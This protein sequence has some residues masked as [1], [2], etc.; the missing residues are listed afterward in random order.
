MSVMYDLINILG[1]FCETLI[2]YNFLEIVAKKEVLSKGKLIVTWAM[3]I[4]VQILFII[5]IKQQIVITAAL[6]V[7]MIV[8]SLFFRMNWF[9]RILSSV[10]ILAK[11]GIV[12]K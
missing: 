12:S 5:F 11:P 4:V 2:I 3:L 9:A 7:S 6:F 10:I 8:M 1:L